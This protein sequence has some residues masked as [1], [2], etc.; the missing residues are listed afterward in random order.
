MYYTRWRKVGHSFQ[1]TENVFMTFS[2]SEMRIEKLVE[3]NHHH[4]HIDSSHTPFD[5]WPHGHDDPLATWGEAYGK[6]TIYE[7]SPV[8]V[9]IEVIGSMDVRV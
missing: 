4:G 1:R 5:K 7:W 9:I 6:F 2:G 8:I 3:G